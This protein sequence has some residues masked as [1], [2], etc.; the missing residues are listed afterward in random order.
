MRRT[1]TQIQVRVSSADKEKIMDRMKKAGITNLTA[2]MKKMAID[3]YI[4]LL[5]MSDV[6]DALEMLHVNGLV[7]GELLE[8]AEASEAIPHDDIVLLQEQQDEIWKTMQQI[9]IRL[10]N[11]S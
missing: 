10:S 11:I 6:K 1:D 9:L 5:D 8:R 7:L 3:G 2:Y 4:I